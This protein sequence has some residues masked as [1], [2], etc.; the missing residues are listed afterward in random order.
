VT[1]IG[2]FIAL[3]SK[4]DLFFLI[5][6]SAILIRTRGLK[7]KLKVL[8]IVVLSATLRLMGMLRAQNSFVIRFIRR[9]ELI[10]DSFVRSTIFDI[11]GCKFVVPDFVSLWALSPYVEYFVYELLFSMLNA[12]DIFIDVGVHIR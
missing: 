4:Q 6:L 2:R 10:R 5:D 8:L 11:D 12:G 3:L 1:K 7:T 9:I